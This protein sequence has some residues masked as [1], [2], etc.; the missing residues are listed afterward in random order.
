MSNQG[1][2]NIVKLQV[3]SSVQ[4]KVLVKVQCPVHGLGPGM[5][6]GA[7][8]SVSNSQTKGPGETLYIIKQ[9]TTAPPL[10]FLKLLP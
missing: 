6:S 8:N 2:P 10:N 3:R 7:Q 1:A 9:T 5:N 4:V